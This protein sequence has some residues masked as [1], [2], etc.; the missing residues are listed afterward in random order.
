MRNIRFY[1]SDAF[2]AVPRILDLARKSGF[3]LRSLSV[4]S[5]EAGFEVQVTFDNATEVGFSTFVARTETI[6]L[7]FSPP[8][9][10]NGRYHGMREQNRLRPR[11]TL[12]SVTPVSLVPVAAQG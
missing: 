3:E 6:L 2:D 11:M 7:P 10:C 8:A 1:V 5:V 9:A 12:V 4:E